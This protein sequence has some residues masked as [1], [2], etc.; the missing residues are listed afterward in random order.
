M[1]FRSSVPLGSRPDGKKPD[2]LSLVPWAIPKSLL[3]D[4]TCA[5]TFAKSYLHRTSN[6]PGYA[7]KQDKI[8]KIRNTNI[9]LI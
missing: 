3:W 4:Y 8:R 6:D 1:I 5:D 2:W 9:T 7:A